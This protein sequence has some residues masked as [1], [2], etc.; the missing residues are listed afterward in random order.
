MN[1]FHLMV[2]FAAF[3]MSGCDKPNPKAKATEPGQK[4]TTEAPASDHSHERGKMLLTDAGKYHGLL[5]AHLSP[6]G[7]EL[8]IFF[9]TP[10]SK[11][12]QPVALPLASIKTFIRKG[13]EEAKEVVFQ[14]APAD[15]RPAGEKAGTCSHFVAKVPWMQPT[16]TLEVTFFLELDGERHRVTWEKFTPKKYAHHEE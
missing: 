4:A 9:E 12:P 15:E 6:K 2:A 10:V 8:D 11:N 13:D 5:T 16:D 7:N 14:P 1:R 3:A